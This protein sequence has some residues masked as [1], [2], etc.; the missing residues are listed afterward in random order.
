MGRRIFSAEM[1]WDLWFIAGYE[2]DSLRS[3]CLVNPSDVVLGISNFF[4]PA[5]DP[6][7]WSD[8]I[9]FIRDALGPWDIVGYER[10]FE[11]LRKLGF[12]SPGDLSVWVKR[13]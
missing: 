1:I 5:D 12:E 4:A 13:N 3:G 8:M 10:E 7:Y 6:V 11:D 2:G 9:S